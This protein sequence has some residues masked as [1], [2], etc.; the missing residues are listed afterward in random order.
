MTAQLSTL[1]AME[2]RDLLGAALEEAQTIVSKSEEEIYIDGRIDKRHSKGIW[3][4]VG[5]IFL[6]F[7]PAV[8]LSIIL[9]DELLIALFCVTALISMVIGLVITFRA[10]RK[11]T[12]ITNNLTNDLLRQR[13]EEVVALIQNAT[14]LPY[15]PAD[16]RS[17][18]ALEYMIGLLDNG[19][20]DTW[21]ECV[22]KWEEQMHRWT[23]ETNSAEAAYHSAEAARYAE[24]AS[25]AAKWAAAGAWRR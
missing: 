5:V 19:R 10:S 13:D 9:N 8:I 14:R 20:A 24:S 12:R 2:L 7:L 25:R 21:R 18:V 6:V 22:D 23:L 3:I 4:G 15:I 16:Y 11:L 1:P 17:M